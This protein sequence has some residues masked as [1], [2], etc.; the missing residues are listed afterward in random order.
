[1]IAPADIRKEHDTHWLDP[2]AATKRSHPGGA[3]RASRLS[4]V[5]TM[6]TPARMSNATPVKKTYPDLPEW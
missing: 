5:A 4:K 1:M 3:A 6:R 2:V